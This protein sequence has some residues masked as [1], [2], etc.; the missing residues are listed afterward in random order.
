M[1][2]VLESKQKEKFF[3]ATHGCQMNVLDSEIVLG[4]LANIGFEQTQVVGDADVVLINTCSVRE[5]AEEKVHTRLSQLRNLK[6]EKP[7]VVIGVLGC[8]AQKERQTFFKLYPHVDLVVGTDQFVKVPEFVRSVRES[9]ERILAIDRDP[10][11][12]YERL[13]GA[14]QSKA[15]AFIRVMRGCD[16]VCSFCVVP[17]TRGPEVSMAPGEIASEAK[18]LADDGVKEITLLG[19]TVNAYGDKFDPPV[20][21]VRVIEMLHEVPGIERIKFIT[22]HPEHRTDELID[23]F[24]GLPKLCEY[25]HLPVQSGS[26]RILENMRR[27]YTREQY[28]EIV[29]RLRER[30]PNVMLATDFIVGYPSETAEDFEETMSLLEY[31]KFGA[32]FVFKYSPRENTRAM[33]LDDDVPREEKRARNLAL[34]NLQE[35]ISLR[36]HLE[37]VGTIQEVLV[38]GPSR[39]PGIATG[40]TRQHRIVHFPAD[41]ST[42]GTLRNVTIEDATPLTMSGTLLGDREEPR[43]K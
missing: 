40:R 27:G 4:S 5:K 25:F 9:R 26:T 10:D 32:S 28:I 34:L 2:T 18:V 35:E 39:K 3:I 12:K 29:D 42:Y 13:P 1:V 21:L 31:A 33:R 20:S 36:Q 23:A 30:A 7:D 16:H 11:F 14:R 15:Q 17:R 37:L 41:D 22:S 24:A 43:T 8:M 6:R 19:Q 38:E